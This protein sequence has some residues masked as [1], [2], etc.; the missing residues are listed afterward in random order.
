MRTPTQGGGAPGTGDRRR[1]LG[2]RPHV[3]EGDSA[4]KAPLRA[5][6]R[7]ETLFTGITASAPILFTICYL[8]YRSA[9]T[10]VVH[11]YTF[12]VTHVSG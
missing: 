12:F 10:S 4:R 3:R 5:K 7:Y 9:I 1:W 6:L 2:G 8:I 11:K